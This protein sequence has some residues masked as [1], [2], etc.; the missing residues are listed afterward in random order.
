MIQQ[1]SISYENLP[2]GGRES[3]KTNTIA[4]PLQ[5]HDLQILH[6]RFLRRILY[7]ETIFHTTVLSTAF[8]SASLLS[9]KSWRMSISPFHAQQPQDIRKYTSATHNHSSIAL[10]PG[11]SH[12]HRKLFVLQ[13]TS[14]TR[15]PIFTPF[16]ENEKERTELGGGATR[17]VLEWGAL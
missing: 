9:P 5:E 12:L 2:C 6:L 1:I 15:T 13:A 16:R 4:H 11:S 3:L 17:Q 14:I 8:F 10:N 7:P